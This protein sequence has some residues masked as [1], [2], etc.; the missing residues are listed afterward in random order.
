MVSQTLPFKVADT[1]R[2]PSVNVL[3]LFFALSWPDGTVDRACYF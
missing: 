3:T 1:L 2:V